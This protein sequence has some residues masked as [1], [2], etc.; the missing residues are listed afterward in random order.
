MFR[1]LSVVA[2]VLCL[3]GC[4]KDEVDVDTRRRAVLTPPDVQKIRAERH[5]RTILVDER[6]E[7]IASA[8]VVAGITLPRGFSLV[9][10]LEHQWYYRS[11]DVS[12]EQLDRYFL[13]RIE[14][15]AIERGR[16]TIRYLGARSRDNPA[17][18]PVTVRI[19]VVSEG[20]SV[21]EIYVEAPR[22][23]PRARP[24]EAEVRAQLEARRKFAD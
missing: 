18:T 6:G 1:G 3:V 2:V 9:L 22:P 16:D 12:L 8:D 14:S 20:S 13:R 15:R 11:S 24:S 4:A 19:S 21:H 23:G 10:A 5:A 17:S 7:L